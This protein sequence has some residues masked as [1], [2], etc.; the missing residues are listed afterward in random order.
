GRSSTYLDDVR[1]EKIALFCNVNE[2]DVISDPEIENIY[3][4][5][6]IFE[7]EGFGDKILSRFGM[8]QVRPQDKEWTEF[9]EKVK[10][11]ER[12]VKI[13]IV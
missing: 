13:G 3:K 7:R 12:S 2:E 9:I 4:L 10:T 6:L 1:R 8:S 5:P 11:L